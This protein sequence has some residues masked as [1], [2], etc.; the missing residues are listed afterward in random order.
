MS[1]WD[2]PD[3]DLIELYESCDW[4]S[5]S[6][7]GPAEAAMHTHELVCLQQLRRCLRKLRRLADAEPFL[8]PLPWQA[9]GLHDYL[10]V[11]DEPIDL[12]SIGER[13]DAGAYKDDDGFIAPERF[14]ADVMRCWANCMHYYEGYEECLAYQM[15]ARMEDTAKQIR[16]AFFSRHAQLRTGAKV[17]PH[18][19]RSSLMLDATASA[20]LCCSG[21]AVGQA[22][23][24]SIR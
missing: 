4:Q 8:A 2:P 1:T 16:A 14:W 17:E 5:H 20:E 9:L 19:T 12:Q 13:L 21:R 3:D 7:T 6:E 22:K 24:C 10:E 23:R 15:A 11:V 18:E